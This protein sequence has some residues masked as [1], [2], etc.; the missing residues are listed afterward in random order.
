MHYS[1]LLLL[2][3]APSALAKCKCSPGDNCWPSALK[4]KALN[5]TVRGRLIANEPLAM[6]CYTGDMERCQEISAGYLDSFTLEKSPI[7]YQY[8]PIDTCAPLNTSEPLAGQPMCDLGNAPVYS[9][10]ATESDHVAAGIKFAKD[11]NVRLVIKSTGHDIRG[12][13]QGYGSL[14]IWMQNMRP[15]LKFE[16]KYTSSSN[17]SCPSDWTGST[18]TICAGY[19]WN[20]VYSFAAKHGVIVVGGDDM[21]VGT[22]GGYIQGGGHGPASHAFGLA[23]DQVLEYK[24]VLASGELVTA[25]A[26]QYQDL[27]TALRGGG[28][29]TYGVV[30]SATIKAYPTRA[31]LEH[32][33]EIVPVAGNQSLLTGA[34]AEIISKFPTL[35]DEGFAGVGQLNK[36]GTQFVYTHD[37]GVLLEKNSSSEI[38]HAREV[39]TK[40]VV[41]ALRK[42]N[43][44]EL[45]VK[46]QF[47]QHNTFQEYYASGSHYAGAAKG[48]ILISRFF[49][50]ES[51][52]HQ[53]KKLTTMLD[54]LF[55]KLDSGVQSPAM[56]LTLAL[57][58]GGEVLKPQPY[59]SVHPAWRRTYMIAEHIELAP[60]ASGM[61]GLRQVWGRAT[62]EKLKAMKDVTPGMGTYLNE[63]DPYDPDWKEAW[64]GDRYD[65]LKLTKNKY[66]PDNIF[67][68]WRCVGSEGWD[69]VKGPSLW[70]PLCENK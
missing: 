51:M 35:S 59:T 68:C 39:M 34:V 45:L 11:N 4:W 25:N 31:V 43:G 36:M 38:A 6:P 56:S 53:E 50:K 40:E 13:S 3:A 20:D 70:G 24:V 29:G 63:A 48:V 58:G 65:E 15:E 37:F 55:G 9:I 8:S 18:I 27:F 60:P 52:L 10:N 33:L 21:S 66:D 67:W 1:S 49:N 7:G 61:A 42:Y 2:L 23:T 14:S 5:S 26:C 19:V 16:E 17:K 28:G 22:I 62:N 32:T 30:V 44:T 47:Q 64:Y 57:I 41:D 54:T 69:E 12:R 46:S